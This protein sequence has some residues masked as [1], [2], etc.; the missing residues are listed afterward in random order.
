MLLIY[1]PRAER[2]H[3]IFEPAENDKNG[4]MKC[5]V[6][7]AL[8]VAF[9]KQYLE[10]P[11]NNAHSSTLVKSTLED[12][13]NSMRKS[14]LALESPPRKGTMTFKVRAVETVQKYG[15]VIRNDKNTLKAKNLHIPRCYLYQLF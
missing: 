4:T 15:E 13:Q 2:K 8:F 6:S 14:K 11:T 7:H 12:A 9:Q 10:V 3:Q 5:Q 1:L